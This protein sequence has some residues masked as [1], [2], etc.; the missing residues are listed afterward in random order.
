MYVFTGTSFT[1]T[2]FIALTFQNGLK[3]RNAN[4][5]RLHIDD[6]STCDKNLISFHPENPEFVS[7]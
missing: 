5:K 6:P 7:H 2:L 3:Y 1:P 4:I